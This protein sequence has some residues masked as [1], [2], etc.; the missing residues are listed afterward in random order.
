MQ[1]NKTPYNYI[2]KS[3]TF[4]IERYILNDDGG[5][6]YFIVRLLWRN[7]AGRLRRPWI[8]ID[9]RGGTASGRKIRIVVGRKRSPF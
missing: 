1:K 2:K 8:D 7:S 9:K 5:W 6:N 3:F 4:Y